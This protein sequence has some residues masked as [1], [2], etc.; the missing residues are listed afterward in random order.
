MPQE[1]AEK[2]FLLVA[3]FPQRSRRSDLA[4]L[5]ARVEL[6]PFP[7][8]YDSEVFPPPPKDALTRALIGAR[9]AQD[10]RA[11]AASVRINDQ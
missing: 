7:F 5:T 4:R 10:D 1:V 9:F 8:V 3:R 6:V 11:L 2:R